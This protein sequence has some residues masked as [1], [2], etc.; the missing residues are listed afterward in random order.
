MA[1]WVAP[2]TSLLG[3]GYRLARSRGAAVAAET[4]PGSGPGG[5]E[6]RGR[7]LL[8]APIDGCAFS[9]SI[10]NRFY[11]ALTHGRLFEW[12]TI[13]KLVPVITGM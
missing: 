12:V 2:Q 9:K 8:A 11:D 10:C 6:R 1:V 5:V 4:N 3:W 13:Q 7:T